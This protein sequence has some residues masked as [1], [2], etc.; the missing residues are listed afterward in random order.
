MDGTG[1]ENLPGDPALLGVQAGPRAYL[2]LVAWVQDGG[3]VLIVQRLFAP[4]NTFRLW[5]YDLKSRT[6]SMV[7]ENAVEASWFSP[8]SPREDRLAIKY[9][10]SAG[11]PWALALLDLRTLGTTDITGGQERVVSA[12]SWD[13]TGD[14]LAYIIRRAQAGG[15]DV[16]VL[17]VY[18]LA[19]GKT[20]SERAMTDKK[21][22]ALLL[23]PAWTRRRRQ[24]PGP[25]PD[26]QAPQGPPPRPQRGKDD[27]L[28]R[29]GPPPGR[30]A[31]RGRSCPGR[32]RGDRH[33]LAAG[34][35]DG[36]LGKDPLSTSAS[37]ACA[38][39][40]K[41]NNPPS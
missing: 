13:K 21:S 20:V 17:A 10:K 25:G 35:A 31:D 41:C 18:S 16:Y 40:P 28:S 5:A 11:K 37:P 34:P 3:G 4:A 38:R 7:L 1:L 14:R 30:P 27:R 32:G 2:H 24:A 6:A 23:S 22:D 36:V 12:V 9:Q 8:L 39:R 33:A 19:A 26:G 15:P 29:P